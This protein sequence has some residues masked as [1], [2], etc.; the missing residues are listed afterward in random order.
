MAPN[1][2]TLIVLSI[3]FLLSFNIK[4]QTIDIDISSKKVGQTKTSM[5]DYKG[6][7][8]GV[9]FTIRF[10][11]MQITQKN[12][13]KSDIIKV[14]VSVKDYDGEIALVNKDRK[15]TA[16]TKVEKGYQYYGNEND[17]KPILGIQLDD[18]RIIFDEGDHSKI[19]HDIKRL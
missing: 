18:Q 2:R 11:L 7:A 14:I 5:A 10:E 6:K 19:Y 4:G 8:D 17:L 1:M 9:I 13:Y 12:G 16:L 15:K 3:C